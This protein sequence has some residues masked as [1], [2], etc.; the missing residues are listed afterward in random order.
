MSKDVHSDELGNA[1]PSSGPQI[2]NPTHVTAATHLCYTL[3][4]TVLLTSPPISG[5]LMAISNP[6]TYSD[7]QKITYA[8]NI[9]EDVKESLCTVA[10]QL[11]A[12]E[13]LMN[14]FRKK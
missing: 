4:H 9:L 7:E 6:L 3:S 5:L 13:V 2:Q 10:E 1:P 12:V 8:I 14:G 11:Q